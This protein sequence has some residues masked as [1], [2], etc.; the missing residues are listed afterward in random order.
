MAILLGGLE[1]F[2]KSAATMWQPRKCRGLDVVNLII[3]I[4]RN[5]E[6]KL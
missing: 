6:K 3:F 5:D 4:S 2:Y 1:H